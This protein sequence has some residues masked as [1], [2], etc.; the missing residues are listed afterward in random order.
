M[1]RIARLNDWSS[2]MVSVELKRT[3]GPA[4][5]NMLTIIPITGDS[6][7]IRHHSFLIYLLRFSVSLIY[8]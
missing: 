7:A 1:M 6:V 2:E 8:I 5:V 3:T 4:S